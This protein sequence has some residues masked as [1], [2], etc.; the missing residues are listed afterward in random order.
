MPRNE[1]ALISRPQPANAN[2]PFE[3]LVDGEE[4]SHVDV[5]IARVVRASVLAARE[6]LPVV[7]LHQVCV[8]RQPTRVHTGLTYS[9]S[10]L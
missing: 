5:V 2:L 8:G 10:A 7:R 6:Q 9:N 1:L 3:K 4:R